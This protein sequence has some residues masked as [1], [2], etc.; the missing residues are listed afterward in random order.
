MNKEKM[1]KRLDSLNQF[2]NIF[3]E[4][5]KESADYTERDV[6]EVEKI[7]NL[8]DEKI[9]YFMEKNN[10]IDLSKSEI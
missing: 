4:D 3:I 8:V 1:I 5:M 6:I 7:R 9:D 10:G 2:V